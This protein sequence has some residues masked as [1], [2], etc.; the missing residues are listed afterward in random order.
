MPA[1]RRFFCRAWVLRHPV[2]GL[3]LYCQVSSYKYI[4][5]AHIFFFQLLRKNWCKIH[6]IYKKLSL[7]CFVL[8]VISYYLLHYIN[9]HSS[10]FLGIQIS[11][12]GVKIFKDWTSQYHLH[13]CI[14]LWPTFPRTRANNNAHSD[15]IAW[16]SSLC[17][18]FTGA[19]DERL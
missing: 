16:T 7:F 17:Y 18:N 5:P 19:S 2:L 13:F 8:T 6:F 11:S 1:H 14:A 15:G 12:W 3:I 10:T 9:I 4:L